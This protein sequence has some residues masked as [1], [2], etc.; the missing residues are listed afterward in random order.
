MGKVVDF[1]TARRASLPRF[2]LLRDLGLFC[3][4]AS[5]DPLTAKL[6]DTLARIQ[7]VGGEKAVL[8]VTEGYRIP[9]KTWPGAWSLPREAY[10]DVIDSAD[11][12]LAGI[13]IHLLVEGMMYEQE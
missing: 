6:A 4:S 11:V 5:A 2:G 1:I 8:A 12:Y 7:R 3:P 10:Q 13:A 9:S